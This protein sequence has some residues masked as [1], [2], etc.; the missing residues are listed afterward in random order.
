MPISTFQFFFLCGKE[1][2]F[3]V[4]AKCL[5]HL[6]M[7]TALIYGISI[8]FLH[9][10]KVDPVKFRHAFLPHL[11][12]KIVC[13]KIH[14]LRWRNLPSVLFANWIPHLGKKT[15]NLN[16]LQIFFL[17]WGRNLYDLLYLWSYL[18]G[19][20]ETATRFN[21]SRLPS[22]FIKLKVLLSD[23]GKFFLPQ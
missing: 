19:R 14:F 1:C 4:F 9:L 5:L 11:G 13:S 20:E 3:C 17:I 16:Q 22:A 18:L 10:E 21:V 7:K 8:F 23:A 12:K 2:A 6:G 15:T